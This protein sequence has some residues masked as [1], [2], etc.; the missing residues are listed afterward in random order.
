MCPLASVVS[1]FSIGVTTLCF[2]NV[3]NLIVNNFYKLEPILID[4]GTLCADTT[5]F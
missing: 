1:V 3:T 2:K 4:F 5:G